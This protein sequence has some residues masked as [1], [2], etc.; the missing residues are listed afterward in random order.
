[1]NLSYTS[2]MESIPPR[3]TPLPCILMHGSGVCYWTWK[4]PRR[5]GGA[6]TT[7]IAAHVDSLKYGRGFRHVSYCRVD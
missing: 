2:K 1:M 3:Q 5:R 4:R 7:V 6:G